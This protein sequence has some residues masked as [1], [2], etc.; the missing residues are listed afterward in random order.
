MVAQD[1]THH[2][3]VGSGV[4]LPTRVTVAECVGSN[5]LCRHPSS[6]SIIANAM[7]ECGARER[8]IG[9]YSSQENSPL[10][11]GA[12]TFDAEVGGK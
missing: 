8:F 3:K 7:P 11:I 12:R 10:V 6:L 1:V 2:F 5:H 4:D 9:H